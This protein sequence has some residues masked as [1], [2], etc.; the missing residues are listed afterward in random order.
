MAHLAEN[1]VGDIVIAAPVGGPLGEGKLIHIVAVQFTRQRFGSRVDFAGA[2]HKM[3]ASAVE[4]DLFDFASGGA[5]GHHG[6]KRQPQQAGEIGLRNC[7]RT[8]RRFDNRGAFFDPAVAQAIEKQRPRQTM[9][10]A[11]GR[12]RTFILQINRDPRKTRQR[13]ANQVCIG[14]TLIVGV[15]F[16]NGV[17]YPGAIHLGF[18]FVILCPA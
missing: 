7:S 12:M 17:F 6:D 16:T 1:T 18:L 15:N 10:E 8:R 14:G 13:Q 2:L 3:A 11:T 9:F 4:L 5:G